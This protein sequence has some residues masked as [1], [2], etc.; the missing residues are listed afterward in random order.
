MQWRLRTVRIQH[1]TRRKVCRN[2]MLLLAEAMRI[3]RKWLA[4]VLRQ[5][6]LELDHR[7][8]LYPPLLHHNHI[9]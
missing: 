1:I 8:R 7:F 6:S 2:I 3:L 5:G 9:R 4:E